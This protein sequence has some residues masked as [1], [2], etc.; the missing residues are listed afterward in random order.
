MQGILLPICSLFFS[1]LLAFAYFFRKRVDLIENK[2]YSIM[3][4]CS[5]FD[6][7]LVSIL[8]IMALDGIS[9]NELIL[10]EIYNKLDF[11][12]LIIFATCIFFYVLLI[13]IPFVKKHY[14]KI[15]ASFI[16]I[17]II[18]II[19]MLLLNVELI[20]YSNNFSITGSAL[21]VT[22]IL[23]ATYILLSILISVIN[24]KRVDKRHIPVFSIIGLVVFLFIIF[25]INPYLIV[26]SITLT[27]VN[28]IMYFTIE[29]PD[30]KMI[31]KLN[32]AKMN[33]E[34]AN[35]AKSDFLSSMS[36]EIRTPLN[37]IVGFSEMIENETTIAGCKENAKDIVLASHTL[38]EIVNG[39]LDISKIEANK[40]EIVNKEYNLLSEL[41]NLAKLM[42]PRIG[43]KP[44]ELKTQFAEDIPAV[45]YGDIGKIKQVITN[46]LTNA[47]KYTEKGEINFTVNCINEKD[48]CSLVI[49][50][51]DTGRGIKP[52]K[53][54]KLFTKFDRLDE[55]LN[56]TIEGTGLGLAITK[57]LTEM[58]GGK[59]IVQS[60]YGKG[61]KFTIYLRQK[62]VEGK[63]DIETKKIEED[64]ISFEGFKILV[65]DDNKL[66][67]KVADKLLKTYGIQT[68]LIESGMECID[69]IKKGE[70][71]DLILLD[72]MM[73]RLRGTDVL[74]RLKQIPSFDIP[75]VIL[76]ANATSGIK[77]TYLN[78]GFDD[79]LAKPIEKSE[80]IRVLKK[81]LNEKTYD[82][83]PVI[84]DEIEKTKVLIVDD[85]KLNIKIA[86]TMMKTYDFLID[87]A[88]SGSECIEKVKKQHYDL[89]FMDYMMPNMD[90]IETLNK[91]KTLPNFNT[92]VV[93]LTAD[94]TDGSREKFLSSGFDE[95]VSKP[96]NKNVLDKVINKMLNIKSKN[97]KNL[98]TDDNLEYLKSNG[99][100]VEHGLEL[101]GD[102][103][104]YND[105]LK[106]FYEDFNE[107]INKIKS[108]KESGDMPSYAIETHGLKSDC[109]Y[110][111]FT[112]LA[113][114][115]YKHELAS[116]SNDITFVNNN[117]DELVTEANKI[118]EIV[119]KYFS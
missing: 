7:L 19:I 66:N 83:V 75:T 22:Y 61:S 34:K 12:I 110:L 49:S 117:Y 25:K 39:I 100:D 88:L 91:L 112:S 31:E 113:E 81:Y 106:T 111:G 72:D 89:I 53:I 51:E 109:K 97:N 98:N 36:H 50:V 13:T 94:A 58:M 80:L 95:Y 101:L 105:S 67:L 38:L 20:N 76:T 108:Y 119:K 62:I 46:V 60:V 47:C 44:I 116:K 115:A 11:I 9:S 24:I 78:E 15:F 103:E 28:Y 79:Y 4:L 3:L 71:Y 85:N 64:N 54:D 74:I 30:V 10:V 18:S 56:T 48:I 65:V 29:N 2:M 93:A 41:E 107:R 21:N 99:I 17:D 23:C 14:K 45:M 102:M 26:V 70:K 27:F 42:V 57:S 35:R 6:S 87:E 68:V 84:I 92:S 33:A 86:S 63:N 90:G 69:L 5:I 8:Q 40:M 16:A 55:D 118:F 73:P 96:I 1:N 114:I 37:A 32:I 82:E 77:D 59:I 52:D 104:M 43:E